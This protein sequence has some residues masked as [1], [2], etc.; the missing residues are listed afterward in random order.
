MKYSPIFLISLILLCVFGCGNN[1]TKKSINGI[2]NA[3]SFVTDSFKHYENDYFRFDY[4]YNMT[5]EEEVNNISDS[6]EGLKE[7]ISITLYTIDSPIHFRFVK[8]AMFNV[9]D[10]PEQWRDLSIQLK[11][12]ADSSYIGLYGLQD[13]LYFNDSPAASV[14]FAIKGEHGDTLVQYQLVVLRENKDLFYLNYIAPTDL[15]N[16]AHEVADTVFNSFQFK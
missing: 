7:G 4:P 8:S 11:E 2:D 6:I 16:P 9:F 13:S 15:F 3:T 14:T 5:Y 1:T 12:R 10:S